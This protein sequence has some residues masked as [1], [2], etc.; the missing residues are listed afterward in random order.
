MTQPN[1]FTMQIA[2]D[3]VRD[4]LG[5]ALLNT[6]GDVVAEVFRSDR[7]HTVSVSTFNN[8]LPLRAIQPLIDCA[9]ER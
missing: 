8:D 4:G 5:I 6:K 1:N 9:I 2:S 3:V 7:E